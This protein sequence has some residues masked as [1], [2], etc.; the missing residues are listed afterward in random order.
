MKIHDSRTVARRARRAF[1]LRQVDV[2]AKHFK[3]TEVLSSRLLPRPGVRRRERPAPARTRSR[4][5]TSSPASGWRR[6]ADGHR[7]HQR[8]AR[9]AQAA[10]WHWPASTTCCRS[11]IVLDLP[12]TLC[13]ERNRDRP[14]R[15]F[16]PHVIRQQTP[17]TSPVASRP[18]AEGFRHVSHVSSRRRRSSAST[19]ERQPLWNNRRHDHGPFDI[20]GDVHGCFDELRRAARTSSAIESQRKTPRRASGFAVTPPRAG[21]RCSSATWSTAGREYAGRAAARDE[22]GRAGAALCVPGNHDMKLLRKL[23]GQRR[24]DH[25]R[26]GRALEQLGARA[27]G[28]PAEVAKFLD[29]CQPLRARRREAGGRPRRHEG[30]RCR[31]A[32][33]ARVREFALYGETTGETDEFGLP[34]RYNWAAEY[35]G[36]RWSSTATRRCRSRSG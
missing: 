36:E 2:R 8:P 4:C 26:P 6:E 12:E 29:G 35:R 23:R 27:A 18:G 17:A 10:S 25:A 1:R 24:A 13:H 11:P 30:G 5:C 32:A 3:P 19:I 9:G 16:G 7:R 34:V 14:D 22:H 21:R 28:V 20:I 31:A 15:Q 33:P